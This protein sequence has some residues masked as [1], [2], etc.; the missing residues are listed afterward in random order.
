VLAAVGDLACDPADPRFDGGFGTRVGCAQRRVSTAVLRDRQLAAV[1]TLG[2]Y[3]YDCGDAR[4]YAVS[5][6]PTWG[7]LDKLVRP[8]AG[9]HEYK[10]GRDAFGASCPT[11]NDRAENYFRHFGPK[12]HPRTHGHFSFD[13]GGWHLIALNGNCDGTGVGGCGPNSPQTRWLR[14]D[15]ASTREKCIAAFWHQPLFT[16]STTVKGTQ[17]RSWWY[18]LYAAHADLI[19]N[20]H[21]HNYQRYQPLRPGGTVDWQNGITEYVVGTGGEGLLSVS[22][23]AVPHPAVWY[24]SFGYLRLTLHP[25]RWHSEFVNAMGVARDSLTRTC[26]A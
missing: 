2:D 16:G 3:Q 4:D 5:Y 19:L 14:N 12:S 17:Y 18:A 15:L 11:T 10:T 6:D 8:V 20:G 13:I 23:H 9:N 25:T 1:L 24:K 22:P 21:L 7:R 26:H